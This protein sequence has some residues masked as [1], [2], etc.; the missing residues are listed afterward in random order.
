MA[1]GFPVNDEAIVKLKVQILRELSA[2]PYP[3]ED[4]PKLA[5]KHGITLG[6][7]K[8]LVERHGWP[9]PDAMGRAAEALDTN[10]RARGSA[11]VP[12]KRTAPADQ[13]WTPP[14]TGTEQLIASGEKSAKARTRRLAA[15]VREDLNVL[16]ELVVAERQEA[17]TIAAK[18]RQAELLRVEVAEL[19]RQLAEKKAALRPAKKAATG[20]TATASPAAKDIRAWAAAHSIA[21]PAF[22]RVPADVVEAYEL[23]NNSMGQGVSA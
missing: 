14:A 20:T 7:A 18:A 2:S 13:S 9:N 5:A 16:R 6:D 8:A 10:G 12:V 15:K 19:E 23:A 3:R 22:G 17:E 21:C 1:P 11:P 4:L